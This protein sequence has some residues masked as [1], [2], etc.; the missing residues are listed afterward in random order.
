L[1]WIKAHI[2]CPI[3]RNKIFCSKHCPCI[4]WK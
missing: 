2:V 4:R 3:E 1:V